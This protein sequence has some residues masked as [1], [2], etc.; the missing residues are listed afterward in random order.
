M[1][2]KYQHS[3]KLLL[4]SG[5]DTRVV[6]K[7][8]M[9]NF[10]LPTYDCRRN[11]YHISDVGTLRAGGLRCDQ[12]KLT[13]H[14]QTPLHTIFMHSHDRQHVVFDAKENK[15]NQTEQPW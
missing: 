8:Y 2:R 11:Q 13:E 10:H 15:I 4:A 3:G 6:H 12:L 14:A 5:G 1:H 7:H 9:S